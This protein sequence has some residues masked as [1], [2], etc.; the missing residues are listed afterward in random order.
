MITTKEHLKINK[1]TFKSLLK[2]FDFTFP[3]T[4]RQIRKNPIL[5][6]KT[7]IVGIVN[8]CKLFNTKLNY[9]NFVVIIKSMQMSIQQI[10]AKK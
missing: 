6:F 7:H 2:T 8:I 10:K 9:T 1:T 5:Y 4:T 3:A